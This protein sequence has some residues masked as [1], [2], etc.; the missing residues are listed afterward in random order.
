MFVAG[1]LALTGCAALPDDSP[2]VEQL[3]AE[4]GATITRAGHPLELV[5]DSFA[6]D[7]ASRFA[8]LGPFETNNAG[9]RELFLWVAVPVAAPPDSEPA[10]EV[11]GKALALGTPGAAADF[12]NLKSSP[13]KLPTPWSTMYYYRIDSSIVD[14]LGGAAALAVTTGEPTKDG[15]VRA[16]F[17][18]PVNADPRLREFAARVK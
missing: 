5:R 2:V 7:A 6:S 14:A 10:V 9:K 8:F 16:R 17:S 18:T 15:I 11:D 12:A 13:Y 1:L 4:T 3:D